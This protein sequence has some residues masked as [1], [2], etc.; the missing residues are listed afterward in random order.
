M[1]SLK[2]QTPNL[3]PQTSNPNPQTPNFRPQTPN[4]E[5]E[6]TAK[7]EASKAD[8]ER[9]ENAFAKL[10]VPRLPPGLS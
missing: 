7:Y 5:Q 9:F 6:L 3:K 8:V 4:P 1:P 10:Q 2:P